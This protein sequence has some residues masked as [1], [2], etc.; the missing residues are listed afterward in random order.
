MAT[1]LGPRIDEHPDN[2]YVFRGRRGDL[3]KILWATEDRI[4]LL[5]KRLERGRFIWPQTDGG[6]VHLTCAQ[7]STLLEGID[8]RQ[9]RRTAA[10]STPR[11]SHR[12]IRE[13]RDLLAVIAFNE[14]LHES[15][16]LNALIQ[17][18]RSMR[19]HTGSTPWRP[20]EF[21]HSRSNRDQRP[22]RSRSASPA[23][24]TIEP[25]RRVS[26]QQGVAVHGVCKPYSRFLARTG[27]ALK[28]KAKSP[29][30]QFCHP[31]VSSDS[32]S[33]SMVTARNI[34]D[35]LQQLHR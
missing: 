23:A 14:S 9:P 21:L 10:L 32:I 27:L 19:F 20:S 33:A 11:C 28:G 1:Q 18:K 26:S 34:S 30:C 3:V 35:L 24:T 22:D 8:W 4:W 6:K 12:R 25:K 15:P 7:L 5:A 13:Q 29:D 31:C 16:G 17:F 2:V